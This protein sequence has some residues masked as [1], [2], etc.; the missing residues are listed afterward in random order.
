[1]ATRALWIGLVLSLAAL[2]CG[3]KDKKTDP[4]P[5]ATET[6]TATST[7]EDTTTSSAADLTNDDFSATIKEIIPVGGMSAA[8]AV[9]GEF[10]SLPE[11]CGGTGQPPNASFECVIS[12]VF[13]DPDVYSVGGEGVLE[14]ILL[15][16]K[17]FKRATSICNI[18]LT[19]DSQLVKGSIYSEARRY[20]CAYDVPSATMATSAKSSGMADFSSKT[21][22]ELTDMFANVHFYMYWGENG[23]TGAKIKNFLG[24]MKDTS[25]GFLGGK[26]ERGLFRVQKDQAN[27]LFNSSKMGPLS[28]YYLSGNWTTH[29]FEVQLRLGYTNS[30]TKWVS[31]KA[32]AINTGMK[33]PKVLNPIKLRNNKI[34]K[35]PMGTVNKIL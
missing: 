1:M 25:T 35:A 24:I 29:E 23:A 7:A 5:T 13:A 27:T 12:R 31:L 11:P 17:V 4:V 2:G 34:I 14:G 26:N 6:T 15:A 10:T 9:R 28:G 33:V 32:K 16:D 3:K 22:A 21:D 20:A 8:L 19:G 30:S 18:P